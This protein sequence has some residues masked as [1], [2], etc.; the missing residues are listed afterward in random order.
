[1]ISRPRDAKSGALTIG[2]FARA[3]GVNAGTIRYYERAGLLRMTERTQAGYRIYDRADLDR[4]QFIRRA[5]DLGF[6]LDE[7]ALLLA[8]NDEQVITAIHVAAERRLVEVERKLSEVTRMR[9]ALRSLVHASKSGA[10]TVAD[11]LLRALI[12][13]RGAAAEAFS[14]RRRKGDT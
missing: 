11:P 7:I 6:T 12:P 9:D 5:K 13:E 1:M 3:A 4:V 2:R 14:R 8:L 10:T